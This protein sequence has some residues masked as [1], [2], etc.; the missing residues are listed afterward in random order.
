MKRI[1]R[2]LSVITLVC[3]ALP[4]SAPAGNGKGIVVEE[5]AKVEKI[6]TSRVNWE[7]VMNAIIQVESEGNHRA[8]SGNQVGAMQIKPILVKECN[9]IL[10][11]QNSKK[12]FTLNDRYSVKKSKEMFLLI[13]SFYNTENDIEYAIRSWNG[14]NN[15][16]ERATQRYYE[17][18][19]KLLNEIS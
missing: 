9:R 7:P 1:T 6:E 16:S 12:R 14:G 17:K 3:A 8:K 5:S 18:V 4:A 15:Y 10:E 13:Q 11:M 19:S 2:V